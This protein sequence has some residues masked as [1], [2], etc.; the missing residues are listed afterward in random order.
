MDFGGF[1]SMPSKGKSTILDPAGILYGASE[2]ALSDAANRQA[3]L[4]T[5]YS[6]DVNAALQ[7]LSEMAGSVDTGG[8]FSQYL[9]KLQNYDPTQF[10]VDASQYTNSAPTAQQI[11]ANLDPSINYQIQQANNATEA[12][13]AGRGGLF[14]GA[15]G[16]EL[17]NNAR[18]MAETGWNN[19]RDY[20]ANQNFQNNQ[21]NFNNQ[22]NASNLNNGLFSQQL[23]NYGQAYETGMQPLSALMQS[24]LDKAN[25]LYGTQ[26][27]LNQQQMQGQFTQKG[28]FGDALGAIAGI[29]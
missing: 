21:A 28:Y 4:N 19:A 1:F 18:S 7:P 25:T 15:A 14:S 22:L 23:Q 12:S 20:T 17:A 5:Q 10:S 3:G 8:L 26:S 27:G 6:Q 29:F 24:N 11:Q 16:Q 9:S 2:T 13:A